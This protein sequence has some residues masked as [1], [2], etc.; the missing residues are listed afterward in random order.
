MLGQALCRGALEAGHDVIRVARSHADI[1]LDLKED[2]A[3]RERIQSSGADVLVNCAALVNIALCEE[4]PL[5]AWQV[6][7]RAVGVM[8]ECCRDAAMGFVQISTDHYYNSGASRAQAVGD[9][10]TLLNEY[11]RSKYAGEHQAMLHPD[12]LILRCNLVGFRNRD[13]R[14]FA[15]WAYAAVEEDAQMTLFQDAY[16]SSIDVYHFSQA[17]LQLIQ[18]GATGL[19]NLSSSNVFSKEQFVRAV[20][21][22]LGRDLSRAVSGSVSSLAVQRPS[23]CGLDVRPAENLLGYSLPTLEHIVERLT[24]EWRAI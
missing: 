19:L 5:A 23:C 24:Q 20:A 4:D 18:Q 22:S 10:I 11:A 16:V 1:H 14:T 3:L 12:A 7:A 13:G 21:A 17:L 8:A 2:A 9:P 15:E 6:N